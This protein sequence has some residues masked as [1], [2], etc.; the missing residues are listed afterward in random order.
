MKQKR[1]ARKRAR[2]TGAAAVSAK[3]QGTP[4]RAA[5][6]E[7]REHKSSVFADLFYEDETAEKNLLSL[8]N[9]LTARI[10]GV[11][12]RSTRSGSRMSCTKILRMTFH[13]KWTTR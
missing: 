11:R 9:A 6:K 4:A 3:Q 8:Y 13:L 10:T 2:R 12:K 7:N 5:W 1:A